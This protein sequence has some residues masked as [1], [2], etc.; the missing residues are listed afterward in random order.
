MN[1]PDTTA[2]LAPDLA[3]DDEMNQTS[4]FAQPAAAAPSQAPSARS[5][6]APKR[7]GRL[8]EAKRFKIFSGDANKPLAE[9]VC[10]FIGVPLGQTR[11][12]RFARW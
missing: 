9:E 2:V 11:M 6:A 1:Q 3:R 4:L 7:P 5:G 12:Q 8:S 10:Q